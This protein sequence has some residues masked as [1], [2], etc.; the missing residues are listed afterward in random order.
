[1][2]GAVRV[3][4]VRARPVDSEYDGIDWYELTLTEIDEE[5]VRV[6]F[7]GNHLHARFQGRGVGPVLYLDVAQRLGRRL[8]SSRT[9][10]QGT[11]EFRS[12]RATAI[13]QFL[14]TSGGAEEIPGTDTFVVDGRPGA[15]H[16]SHRETPPTHLRAIPTTEAEFQQL[17]EE[18]DASLRDEGVPIVGR[19]LSGG[20]EISGLLGIT[21]F[22]HLD[23]G[24]PLPGVYEGV[25]LPARILRWFGERYGEKLKMSLSPG[26]VAVL[27]RDDVWVMVLPI[28]IGRH[29]LFAS[30]TERSDSGEMRNDV[31]RPLRYNVLDSLDGLTDGLR[32][33]LPDDALAMCLDVF[34]AGIG[35][36]GAMRDC[37]EEPY[38]RE[39]L[40]DHHAS[41]A[42]LSGTRAH[43]GQAQWSALQAVEKMYKSFLVAAAQPV[44]K[45]GHDLHQLSELAAKAGLEPADSFF[46]NSVQCAAGVRYGE[47][48]TSI[49]EAVTSHHAALELTW[50]IGEEIRTMKGLRR[51]AI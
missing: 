41:V 2:E 29:I 3:W 8:I 42:H 22:P 14:V 43:P 38:V 11:N 39:A 30:R 46:V 20:A 18:V 51:R 12:P 16:R 37:V 48:S 40:T 15:P 31:G 47:I 5:T 13:W 50:Y 45:R 4:R 19:P 23:V 1:M 25:D 6:T 35:A 32:A 28:L 36:Y 44:P 24:E 21:M 34:H 7:V 49:K 33:V 9:T 17:M 26:R 10:S 27:L